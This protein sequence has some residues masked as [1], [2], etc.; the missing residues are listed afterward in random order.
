MICE[1]CGRKGRCLDSRWRG[2]RTYRR[3][4]CSKGHRWSTLELYAKQNDEGLCNASQGQAVT[5]DKADRGRRALDT[6]KSAWV[7]TQ[8]ASGPFGCSR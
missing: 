5:T 4:E 6:Q 1:V 8:T 3:Y 2:D 7:S